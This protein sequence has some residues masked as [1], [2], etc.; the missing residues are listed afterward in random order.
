MNKDS[1]LEALDFFKSL[2]LSTQTTHRLK[3]LFNAEGVI[4]RVYF[5]MSGISAF[6]SIAQAK[7][8]PYNF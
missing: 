8:V 5:S 1:T 3:K 4:N 7:R 2:I 6:W